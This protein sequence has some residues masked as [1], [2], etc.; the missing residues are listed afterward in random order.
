MKG[1]SWLDEDLP[2]FPEGLY[3]IQSVMSQY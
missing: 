2:V 1:I 3:S